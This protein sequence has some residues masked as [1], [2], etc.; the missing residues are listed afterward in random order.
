MDG[1]FRVPPDYEVLVQ[2]VYEALLRPGDVA[3]D[4]GAHVGRHTVPM[5]Q[6][7]GPTGRV[8]AFE[9]LPACNACLRR[10]CDDSHVEIHDCA[11]GASP[12][13]AE[14]VFAV[15]LPGYS[16]LRERIYDQP[17]RLQRLPVTVRTLD[18][19]TADFSSLRLIKVDVE[20]GEMD[21]FRGGPDT[22]QRLRPVVVF[23]FGLRAIG[24]YD[25]SPASAYELLADHDYH[26]YG[27]DGRLL[28][29]DAFSQAA[30]VQT[31]YDYVAVPREDGEAI[32][33][34]ER[35][36]RGPTLRLLQAR[37]ALVAAEQH[38]AQIGQTPAMSRLPAWLRPPARWLGGW[39]FW[40]AAP[41]LA[42]QR[43]AQQASVAALGTLLE[44]VSTLNRGQESGGQQKRRNRERSTLARDRLLTSDDSYDA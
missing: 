35:V 17:T 30:T 7:V 38:V 5:A 22:L 12:G 20:G 31:I 36:L 29:A 3:F 41:F 8:V 32:D 19:M 44:A 16:G 11:L 21:V 25:S 10:A 39:L 15:D 27:I 13:T 9:P 14:F 4:V 42:P 24:N 26:L 23:E 18:E 1:T 40:A 2:L 6:C 43:R 28:D 33:A 37:A 34:V